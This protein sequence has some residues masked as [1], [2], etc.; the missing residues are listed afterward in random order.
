MN[1]GLR[2][3]MKWLPRVAALVV[4]GGFVLFMGAEV[5]YPHSGPPSRWMEWVGIALVSL[6][7]LAPML[8]WKWELEGALLSLS[9]LAAFYFMVQMRN[10]ELMAVMGVPALLFLADWGLKRTLGEGDQ[11]GTL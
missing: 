11:S 6:G 3:V 4:A 2:F 10:L 8:A 1:S 7:C 5:L 9:A